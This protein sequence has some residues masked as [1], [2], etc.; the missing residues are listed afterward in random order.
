M[1]LCCALERLQRI[2]TIAPYRPFCRRDNNQQRSGRR[3]ACEERMAEY[4]RPVKP[5]LVTARFLLNTDVR[6]LGLDFEQ[7]IGP[8][9]VYLKPYWKDRGV[10]YFEDRGG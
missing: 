3:V 8:L 2:D 5:Y 7:V 4:P 1:K 9:R 6:S 10:S